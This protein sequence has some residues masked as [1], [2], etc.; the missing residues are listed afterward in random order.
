M[1]INCSCILPTKQKQYTFLKDVK[2]WQAK[3]ENMRQ[4][5]VL[6]SIVQKVFLHGNVASFA[7]KEITVRANA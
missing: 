4:S 3:K 1:S 5:V 6:F 7:E 2:T